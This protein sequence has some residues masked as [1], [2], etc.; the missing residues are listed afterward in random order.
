M[1][2]FFKVNTGKVLYKN[3]ESLETN[4]FKVLV[5]LLEVTAYDMIWYDITLYMID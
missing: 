3:W 2:L 1:E 5:S 4:S